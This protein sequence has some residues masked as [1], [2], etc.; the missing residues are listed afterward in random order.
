[1]PVAPFVGIGQ[2]GT[3]D[4]CAESHT[5]ELRLIGQ[6]AGF[7]VA[8]TLAVS[9]LRKS[10]GTELFGAAQ[11]ANARI[12]AITLHDSCEAGPWHKLHNLREHRLAQV[13]SLSP[14]IL[15]SGAYSNRNMGKLISNRHQNIYSAT[16]TIVGLHV[17][18]KQFNRTL[19]SLFLSLFYPRRCFY[20]VNDSFN[21]QINCTALLGG[22][23]LSDHRL[24]FQAE[25]L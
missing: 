15:T 23:E 22:T 4:G 7:D 11:A 1:M 20:F 6:Q 10:H 18:N 19:V 8:Q 16:R 14:E 13:H 24:K 3:P 9:Q 21:S 25:P 12:S 2:R 5:I 17:V